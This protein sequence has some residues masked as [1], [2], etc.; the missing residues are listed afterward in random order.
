MKK[1]VQLFLFVLCTTA[2]AQEP[3]AKSSNR[4]G[5]AAGFASR[6]ATILS[7]MGWGVGIIA[8]IATL[9]SLLDNN[10]SSSSSSHSH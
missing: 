6:D 9:F 5:Q 1:L 7:I 2:L 10:S 3:R 8:G 4:Q